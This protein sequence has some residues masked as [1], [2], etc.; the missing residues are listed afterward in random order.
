M[1][2]VIHDVAKS[3]FFVD[4]GDEQAALHYR[5]DGNHIDFVSTFVPL[6][7]RGKGIAEA[8][9]RKGLGWARENHYDISASCWYVAK[10]LT[11]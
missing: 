5:L 2:D 7:A 11:R 9:V 1:T 3:L 6:S 10:F 4:L 8:L